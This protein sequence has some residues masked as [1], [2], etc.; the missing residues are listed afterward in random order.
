VKALVSLDGV[1]VD[2]ADARISVFDR[3][4]LYGDSV[5]EVLRTYGGGPFALI[6]HLERLAR[7]AERA[8]IPLP[9]SVAEFAREVSELIAAAGHAETYLRI[10]LSRGTGRELGLSPGLGTQPLRVIMALALPPQRPELYERGI[11]VITFPT[12]RVS[13]STPAAGAKVSNYLIAVLA[14]RAAELAG[15]EESIVLDRDGRMVE[16]STSNVFFVKDGVLVTPPEASGIL[17]GITREKLLGLAAEWGVP[18]EQRSFFPAELIAA[19]EA[20]ITSSIREV[21]PVV[22]VDGQVVATGRP[23]PLTLRFLEG[24]RALAAAE[25]KRPG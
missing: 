20:F 10:I 4:F 5:F 13:D 16:G 8:L 11:G 2:A 22:R 12:Q 14:T 19:D 24:F 17:V 7:S 15:A 3:G 6:E 25:S 23:G 1:I 18:V 21:A 9:I